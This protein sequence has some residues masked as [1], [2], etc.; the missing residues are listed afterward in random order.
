MEGDMARWPCRSSKL[1][2]PDVTS[3]WVGSTPSSFRQKQLDLKPKAVDFRSVT[4]LLQFVDLSA[5][6]YYAHKWAS[7][8]YLIKDKGTRL[9][10]FLLLFQYYRKLC[11]A[12]F[13]YSYLLYGILKTGQLKIYYINSRCKINGNRGKA[14]INVVYINLSLRRYSR[15]RQPAFTTQNNL[16]FNR[17]YRMR[18]CFFYCRSYI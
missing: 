4:K 3:G 14:V 17:F 2:C 18:P 15:K 6:F 16:F 12:A 7:C 13:S 10:L 11:Y 8:K 5:S 9:A 1:C